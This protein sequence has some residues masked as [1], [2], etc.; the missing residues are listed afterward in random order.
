[1]SSNKIGNESISA[2]GETL[3]LNRTLREINLENCNISK[4]GCVSLARSLKT[5]T[6]LKILDLSINPLLDDGAEALSDGLKYNQGLEVMSLNQCGVGNTGFMSLLESLK[7]NSTMTVLKLCY[8]KIGH[9][10]NGCMNVTS[11]DPSAVS[12]D[13]VY[14]TLCRTLQLNQ[15]LKVLLW[16]NKLDEAESEPIYVNQETLVLPK[17]TEPDYV[18]LQSLATEVKVDNADNV[19]DNLVSQS[20]FSFA[21]DSGVHENADSTFQSE[22][23]SDSQSKTNAMMLFDNSVWN[24]TIVING[25]DDIVVNGRPRNLSDSAPW[26]NTL[27]LDKPP[28]SFST[29]G[30]NLSDDKSTS[31]AVIKETCPKSNSNSK[32]ET[33]VWQIY[34]ISRFY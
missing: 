22:G 2:L 14:E 16:G 7:S 27:A 9:D 19:D 21:S 24:E 23:I 13:D 34:H 5:N 28:R 8:N 15:D 10:V 17:T 32:V 20:S 3:L 33:I 29:D 31:H 18:N 30:V 12:I 1:M 4:D 11:S 25:N 26:T 6:I